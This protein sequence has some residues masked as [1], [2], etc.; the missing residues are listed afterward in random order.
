MNAKKILQFSVGP[1]GAAGLGLITVPFVAW[2]FPVEDVGRLTMLQVV[3]DLTVSLFSL[4]MHQA[5]VREYYEEEDKHTLFKISMLPGL[6]LLTLT[7]LVLLV[8]PFSISEIL[9]GIDSSLLTFLLII[10]VFFRF[11]INFLAHVVRMQER[12]LAF[13]ATQIAPK[14]FLIIL[15]GLIL[16]LN[17]DAEFKI[18]MSMNVLAIFLSLLV[19]TW[20][21]RDTW[22]PA[23]SKSID[24]DLLKQ[25]LKFSLPLVVG[26]L[27][28]MGLTTMDR[29]FLRAMSG[30][31]ELGVYA[32]AASLAA[33]VSVFSTIFSNLWHPVI[34][35]W[36]KEG[37][38]PIK[39]QVVIEN[40]VVFVAFI[41]GLIGLFSWIIPHFLPPEYKAIE[42]LI[43][44]CVAMPLFYMLSETTMVGIGITRRTRFAM[45]ASISSFIINGALNYLL[46]P[47][48]GAAGA[49]LAS[50]MAFF[51]FFTVRTEASARLWHSFPR[52]RIYFLIICYVVI[53]CIMVLTGAKVAYF[54]L[55]WLAL[56]LLTTVLF[57]NRL[58]ESVYF[59][60]S[61]LLRR[62]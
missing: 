32:L 44:A 2:F 47:R 46:I 41:W 24:T 60:K 57:F 22:F 37:V 54:S 7:T 27:A 31:D 10:S 23:I 36:V 12:G 50:V 6:C 1:V 48:F 11:I 40:M 15:I 34:Y 61:Y 49:A 51:F 39:V 56:L 33:S 43:V 14:A 8:M 35:K 20:L 4:G 5:Y 55:V 29:F 53:T 9:F 45:F 30:F 42:Y 25:M 17:L 52:V 28:Y 21:T 26:G 16:L 19:F 13:S 38:D 58:V 62:V 18:L 3:L 59:C